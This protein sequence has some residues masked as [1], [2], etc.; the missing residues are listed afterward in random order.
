MDKYLTQRVRILNVDILSIELSQ[1]LQ[2][3]DEGV[4][5]T[6]N[7]DHIMKL[8]K[9]ARFYEIYHSADWVVCDSKILNLAAAF[10]GRPFAEVI[11]GSSFLPAFYNFHKHNREVSLFLLGAAPGVAE[12]AKNKINQR[13]G[14]EMVVDSYSPSYGFEKNAGE[15][16]AIVDR[17][18]KSG[19]N[20]LVVGVGA[21]KQEKWI[22]EYKAQLP[23]VKRFLALGAT[24]DF[25]AGTIQRAPVLVQKLN[26]EWLYRLLKEPKRLY[27]RY[28]IDDVPFFGLI[29]LQKLRKYKDPFT[30]VT[31]GRSEEYAKPITFSVDSYQNSL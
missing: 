25:E 30:T 26:L 28:L 22:A 5:V 13:V 18:N 12:K 10:L 9:D 19:A 21:P 2:S 4:L 8:Q 11:P 15:C 27:K 24:L 17:I 3:F 31:K 29:A 14:W 16:R 23:H 20:T 1:L 6:P 7:V